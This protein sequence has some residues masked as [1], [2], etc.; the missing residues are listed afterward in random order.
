MPRPVQ[1]EPGTR[2]K[3]TLMVNAELWQRV[4]EAA[5]GTQQTQGQIVEQALAA[6][7]GRK[8]KANAKGE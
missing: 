8:G 7:L 2:R 5:A 1:Y 6:H 3:I 4:T